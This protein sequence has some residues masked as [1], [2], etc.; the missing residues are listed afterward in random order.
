MM[1]SQSPLTRTQAEETVFQ[2]RVKRYFAEARELGAK[3]GFD[4]ETLEKMER[5]YQALAQMRANRDF[6]DD[7][8]L[9]LSINSLH[10]ERTRNVLQ[11]LRDIVRH[12]NY[13]Y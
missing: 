11:G 8:L 12:I 3:E 4:E 10:D 5:H 13:T 1:D 9:A 6:I 7:R 2:I